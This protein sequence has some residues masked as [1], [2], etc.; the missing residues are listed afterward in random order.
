MHEQK[1]N[2]ACLEAGIFVLFLFK[3]TE[4]ENVVRINTSTST[5][6]AG[7][8]FSLICN[9]TSDLPP[10]VTWLDPTGEPVSGPGITLSP[11]V[12][13]GLITTVEVTFSSLLTSQGGMYTCIS[14]ITDP[15]SKGDATYHIRV[16]SKACTH[17]LKTSA[18]LTLFYYLFQSL[19]QPFE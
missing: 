17:Y 2:I 15:P 1:H 11:Q 9:I 6:T 8:Y 19:L 13:N 5:P 4:L 18:Q 10:Q 16:Q 14:D 3:H 12:T 7:R